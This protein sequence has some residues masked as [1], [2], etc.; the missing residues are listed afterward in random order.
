MH[1]LSIEH[2]SSGMPLRS[3]LLD[4]SGG[5]GIPSQHKLDLRDIGKLLKIQ[6]GHCEST[7]L[8]KHF[9]RGCFTLQTANAKSADF[10]KTFSLEIKVNGRSYRVGLSET[11]PDKPKTRIRIYGTCFG[12]MEA[13]GDSF[14]DDLLKSEGCQVVGTTQKRFHYGTN[15]YNGQR[16]ALVV[17]GS[18]HLGRERQW[19][20]PSGEV[21]K[22]RLEYDGQPH[23]CTRGCNA[24]HEDGVCRSQQQWQERRSWQGQQKCHMVGSSLLRLASDTKDVRVDAIPGAKVGHIANHLS[25]DAETF[26]KAEVL[27]LAAG[28]NMTSYGSV[29]AAK[30]HL[31]L[32]VQEL[33]QVVTPLIEATT[34]VFLV[35][36]VE[37]PLLKE[38]PSYEL[39][40]LLRTKMK[41]TAKKMKAEWVSLAGIEW[42]EEDV[43]AD[44]VHWS[45]AGTRKVLN[46]IQSRVKE[47]T[48]KDFFD[49]M[50]V[51]GKPYS[52][53]H[54][55]HWRVG[56]FRCTRMHPKGT[57]PPLPEADLDESSHSTSNI[58]NSFHS[59]DGP[60]PETSGDLSLH[61]SLGTAADDLPTLP[62]ASQ[63]PPA[64][65]STPTQ[66]NPPQP[67][68][69]V[70]S[71]WS[72]DAASP[73]LTTTSTWAD[74]AQPPPSA[75]EVYEIHGTAT[76][77]RLAN[78]RSSSRSSSQKR[79]LDTSSVATEKKQRTKTD[80]QANKE[81]SPRNVTN[82]N[83]R[84]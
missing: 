12:E 56:C 51:Q 6:A 75:P 8:L 74:M 44:E 2:R 48:K 7:Y 16:T 54:G 41:K 81:H 9:N 71:P 61:S 38:D 39:W 33:Q 77:S 58:S 14:F 70:E 27:V 20:S 62:S 72:D 50:G 3:F 46:A 57:C 65:N 24:Y 32:Q 35:D 13:V 59:V 17:R 21:Y 84:K 1:S 73:A 43:E 37:G 28:A 78:S 76:Y 66:A 18:R 5:A 22:W 36:P 10:L 82:K 23:Q 31:E 83:S 63:V 40:S 79:A 55:G 25:H 15:W 45:R 30:P 11:F 60:S 80:G 67:T 19:T 29:E 68:S 34:K 47:V 64:L 52:G 4:L 42:K 49:G 69:F 26:K 53:I